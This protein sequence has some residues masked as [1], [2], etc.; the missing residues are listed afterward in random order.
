MSSRLDRLAVLLLTVAAAAPLA[1]A[2][3]PVVRQWKNIEQGR[4]NKNDN[5]TTRAPREGEVAAF[6]RPD[7]VSTV[8]FPKDR[9]NRSAYIDDARI[10]FDLDRG[11]YNLTWTG[12]ALSVSALL[13][14]PSH[15][16]STGELTVSGGTIIAA[17]KIEVDSGDLFG[18]PTEPEFGRRA[19]ATLTLADGATIKAAKAI[20]VNSGVNSASSVVLRAGTT[21]ETVGGVFETHL[22]AGFSNLEIQKGARWKTTADVDGTRNVGV[23]DIQRGG[24]LDARDGATKKNVTLNAGVV[25]TGKG[26]IIGNVKTSGRVNPGRGFQLEDRGMDITEPAYGVFHI[27]GD[28]EQTATGSLSIEIGGGRAGISYDRLDVSGVA[29]L[30]GSL[31]LSLEGGYQPNAGKRFTVLAASNVSGGFDGLYEGDIIDVSGV[32]MRVSYLGGV[33]LQ[34]I[35]TP[36]AASVCG[37]ALLAALRRRR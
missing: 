33:T 23:F 8:K 2:A 13:R 31:D 1:H 10:T 32:Q 4:F 16:R 29:F 25:V 11:K 28:Y 37:L 30:A 3:D 17:G 26:T 18:Q 35:P 20:H 14:D 34:V 21:L 15:N 22:G 5:W 36:G 19:W 24:T 12:V 6:A 27:D 9:T 7:H